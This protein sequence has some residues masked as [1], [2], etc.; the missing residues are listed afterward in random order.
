[1]RGI[2]KGLIN[3]SYRRYLYIA[4]I[5]ILIGGLFWRNNNLQSAALQN[6]ATKYNQAFS[7][8]QQAEVLIQKGNYKLAV[9]KLTANIVSIQNIIQ[10]PLA[11][12]LDQRLKNSLLPPKD[13][14][15][16]HGL[17]DLTQKNLDIANRVI[18][19]K[20]IAI[21]N[22]SSSNLGDSS[23]ME[24][25]AGK[26][27]IV[28]PKHMSIGIYD[29]ASANI[30]VGVTSKDI[31]DVVAVTT[32]INDNGLILITSKPSVLLYRLDDNSLTPLNISFGVWPSSKSIAAFN[33]NLYILPDGNSQIN[34]FSR[35][36]TGFSAKTNY[37]PNSEVVNIDSSTA[38]AVDG[39]LYVASSRGLK[40]YVAG[41]LKQNLVELPASLSQIKSLHSYN[42]GATITM[43]SSQNRIGII[44]LENQAL[45][46][47]KQFA[48]DGIISLK[49]DV[50]ES[51]SNS[52]YILA[53]GQLWRASL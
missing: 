29:L 27:L 15:S 48:L 44:S 20:P 12:K 10:S 36:L 49:D 38:I 47:K 23:M 34:K 50:I 52:L 39:A 13:P 46:Y 6:L 19:V 2:F 14:K 16:V 35:T 22:L 53:D 33:S 3:K 51:K 30:K 43:T 28:D 4:I 21:A 45:I 26:L 5:I 37:L 7:D 24:I 25:I 18:H 8:E 31:A 9:Q 1:M 41:V 11:N 17:L 42:E 40:R 32:S